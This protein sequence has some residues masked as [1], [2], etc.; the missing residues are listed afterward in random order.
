MLCC[1]LRL[2]RCADK[3]GLRDLRRALMRSR[4]TME[5][6]AGL[7]GSGMG[8]GEVESDSEETRTRV[9]L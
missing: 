5:T 1:S 7:L 2:R 9:G 6:V 8:G 3:G 4:S